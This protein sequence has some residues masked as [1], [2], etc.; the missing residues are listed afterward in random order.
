[1]KNHN[2][3]LF[4]AEHD[5][6]VTFFGLYNQ[7]KYKFNNEIKTFNM[8][9]WN[10]VRLYTNYTKQ[11]TRPEDES[12]FLIFPSKFK[13]SVILKQLRCYKKFGIVINGTIEI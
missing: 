5:N 4:M 1:M 3:M 12:N 7:I 6:L 8:E 9:A 11:T 10:M 13:A 2:I